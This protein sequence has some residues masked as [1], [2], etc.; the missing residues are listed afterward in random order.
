L[1]AG[2][3]CAVALPG[4]GGQHHSARQDS[5]TATAIATAMAQRKKE[6]FNDVFPSNFSNL[7]ENSN[8]WIRSEKCTDPYRSR[9]ETRP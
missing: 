2:G 3:L 1:L 6:H 7:K 5:V 4:A 9:P 8:F